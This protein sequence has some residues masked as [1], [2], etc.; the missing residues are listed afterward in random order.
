MRHTL[1]YD[2]IPV[3]VLLPR[4]DALVFLAVKFDVIELDGCCF[5]SLAEARE[6]VRNHV[7]RRELAAA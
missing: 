1:E 3:G 4:D 7:S 6:A 5:A 2:G